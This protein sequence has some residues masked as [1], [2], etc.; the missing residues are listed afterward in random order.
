MFIQTQETPNPQTLKFLPGVEVTGT[1]DTYTYTK[2]DDT[3][4]SLLATNLL[5]IEGVESIFLGYDF[6]S[7]TKSESESWTVLKPMILATIMDHFV[8]GLP[9]FDNHN[10]DNLKKDTTSLENEDP[11]SGQIREI[12]ET[13]VRPAVAQ[14]GGDIVFQAFEDG[15]VYVQM[16]GACAGCPSSTQT[17]KSGI[18]NMLKFYVP[19]VTEV[20]QVD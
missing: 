5:T 3:K 14:D 15:I 11:V 16:R 4:E 7:I 18:E 17:L 2:N 10:L 6:I 8:A 12:I 1:K 20:K 19:E 13:R 9:V